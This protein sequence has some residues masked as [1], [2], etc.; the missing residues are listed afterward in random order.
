MFDDWMPCQSA[1]GVYTQNTDFPF[2][3]R[4]HLITNN[5]AKK[6]IEPNCSKKTSRSYLIVLDSN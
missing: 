1:T 3:S 6:G 4:L 5:I 2:I